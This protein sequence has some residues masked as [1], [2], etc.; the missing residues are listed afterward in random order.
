MAS[1]S[2]GN[3][4]SG[5]KYIDLDFRILFFIKQAYYQFSDEQLVGKLQLTIALNKINSSTALCEEK[6]EDFAKLNW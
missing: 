3:D 6:T 4:E 1:Y 2:D 5:F